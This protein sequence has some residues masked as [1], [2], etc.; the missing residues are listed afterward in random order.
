MVFPEYTLL[1]LLYF[2]I[3]KSSFYTQ[4]IAGRSAVN[5]G[6]LGGPILQ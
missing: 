1:T 6:Y 3:K 2:P 4:G 5:F